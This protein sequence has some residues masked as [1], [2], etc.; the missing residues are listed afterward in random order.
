MPMNPA[1]RYRAR[2]KRRRQVMPVFC[3]SDSADTG[4]GH[5]LAR[6]EERKNGKYEPHACYYKPWDNT[7]VKYTGL[8]Y[9]RGLPD[10]TISRRKKAPLYLM[11]QPS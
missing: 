10:K 7:K 11:N 1:N 5:P 6:Y 8:F 2:N 4:I 9:L 3:L